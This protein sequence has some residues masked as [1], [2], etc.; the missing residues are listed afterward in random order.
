MKIL[1]FGAGVIG[2]Y[3]ATK[4]YQSEVD[5]TILARGQKFNNIKERG[6]VVEDFFTHQQTVSMIRVIDKPDD[7]S[8]DLIMVAVQMV[9]IN[10]VLPVL[11]EFKNANFFLFIGNNVNGFENISQH[12]GQDR[13][14]A[15]FAA[16]GGKRDGHKVLYAD[17]DPK[18][19]NKKA[20]LVLG[21]VNALS[22]Q[23]FKKDK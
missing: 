21:K 18:K 13:I 19:P 6:V 14:L 5:V 1:V 11:S 3:F 8:Y 20:P 23:N 2:S 9:H 16:V 17:S 7:E 22:D 10:D 15:G 12:L 4:L